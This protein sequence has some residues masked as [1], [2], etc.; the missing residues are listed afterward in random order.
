[1]LFRMRHRYCTYRRYAKPDE[2]RVGQPRRRTGV[3]SGLMLARLALKLGALS[4]RFKRLLWWR[5]Y[6]YLATYNLSDWRFMNY[7]YASLNPS[8]ETVSLNQD[9]EPNRYA[10][11]LYHRVAGAAALS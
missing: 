4:P 1:M 5:W 2:E 6:Q 8:E 10:I 7:G 11:H 9:D 3:L